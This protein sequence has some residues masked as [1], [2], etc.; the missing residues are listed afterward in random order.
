[1]K[2]SKYQEANFLD[3]NN[4]YISFI[5][6]HRILNIFLLIWH[7]FDHNIYT[8]WPQNCVTIIQI[9][10]NKLSPIGSPP[11]SNCYQITHVPNLSKNDT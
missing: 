9:K 4:M 3:L 8:N 1:M 11:I 10:Y 6:L 5:L 7:T 2:Q